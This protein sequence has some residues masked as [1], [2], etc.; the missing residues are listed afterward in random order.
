M[1][2]PLNLTELT[3]LQTVVLPTKGVQKVMKESN[4]LE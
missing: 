2:H 4:G 3:I 1:S